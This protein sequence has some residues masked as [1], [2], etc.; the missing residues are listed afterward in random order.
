MHPFEVLAEPVRRRLV[1]LLASGEHTTGELEGVIIM[2][3]GVGRSAVQHHLRVL[4]D[5]GWID[6]RDDWPNRYFH[7]KHGV[8]S[9]IE[10]FVADFRRLWDH[11]VGWN[12]EER[13]QFEPQ[14]SRKGRRG[15]GKDPDD[16]WLHVFD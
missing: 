16:I 8:I 11:R 3:F 7:L 10:R 5:A 4:R 15:H 1:E 9:H 2:E 6:S 13:F 12:G 14:L